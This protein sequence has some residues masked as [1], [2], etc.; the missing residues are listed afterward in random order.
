MYESARRGIEY[1]QNR[2]CNRQ[3]VNSKIPEDY[4]INHISASFVETVSFWLRRG[5]KETPEALA[6]YLESMLAPFVEL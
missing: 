3:K 6:D 1:A 2:E 5:M 4:L